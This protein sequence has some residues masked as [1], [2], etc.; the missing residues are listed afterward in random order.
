[1]LS[2][3]SVFV[4]PNTASTCHSVTG[5]VRIDRRSWFPLSR[6][7]T[8]THT[9]TP[10]HVQ[11]VWTHTHTHTLS[12]THTLTF[13]REG[14]DRERVN[15]PVASGRCETNYSGVRGEG[16]SLRRARV[17]SEQRSRSTHVFCS[18]HSLTSSSHCFDTVH[19][20]IRTP[21]LLLAWHIVLTLWC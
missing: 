2:G 21:H 11:Y 18:H 6:S 19:L 5:D 10:T 4:Q 9:P 16:T 12:L 1:M 15:P 3:Y 17:G 7:L 8:L 13:C 20:L 14:K